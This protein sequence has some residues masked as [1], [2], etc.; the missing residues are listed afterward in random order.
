MISFKTVPKLGLYPIVDS[1]SWLEKLIGY[2]VKTLQLRIKNKETLD[3]E[4]KEAIKLAK[5]TNTLLFINDHWEQALRYQAQGI[6][7]GQSDLDTA[8]I[9]A[10][11]E[12]DLYLGLSAYNKEEIQR[13]LLYSPS[14]LGFGPIFET[15]SKSLNVAAKGID[16]LK[17]WKQKLNLPLVAIG[18]IQL[19]QIHDVLSTGVDG[20]ALISAITKAKDPELATRTL[21]GSVC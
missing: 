9:K 4:I 12:G 1:L 2:G 20:I 5:K 17:Y 10:I 15:S 21:L 13:A 19:E 8:D 6:H 14:Y 11:H 16:E 7:L 18:G 3:D